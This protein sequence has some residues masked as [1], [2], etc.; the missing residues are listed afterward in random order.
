MGEQQQY[1]DFELKIDDL[2]GGRYRAT[3]IDMPLGEGEAQVSHEFTLPFEDEELTRILAILGGRLNISIA[4]RMRQAR[5]FGETLFNVVFGGPIYTVYFSSRDRA[6]TVSGLRVKLALE[7]AGALASLPWEFLRD[8]AVDYLALSR[9]T[10]LVRHPRRLVIRPRPKFALPLRVLVMVSSPV[11]MPPVDVQAEWNNLQVATET[12]RANGLLELELLADAS[13]RTLQ[14]KLRAEEYH[15]FHYIGHSTY[16]AE[17]GQGM[18][19]L[20]D[21]LGGGGS[22]PVR[23]ED[24]AREL[25]EE[26]TI[27]LVVLNSCQS[28]V[29][30]DTDPFAGIAS[31]IVARGIPAVVAM[32]H[33]IREQAARVFSEELYRSVADGLPVE[34]AMSEARR[35]ISHA[36]GGIQ[37]AVPVLYMRA[38]D[39]MLFDFGQDQR[40]AALWRD[41]R[42]QIGL[43]GAISIVALLLG[44]LLFGPDNE[45]PPPPTPA[46]D[47]AIDQIEV[48][49]TRPAPGQ[50]V[51]I[52]V[53]VTN[54]SN[55][56]VGP[57][58]Y[59]FREDVLDNSLSFVGEINGL[60]A[61]DTAAI[62]IPH[63]FSWW[64]AFVSEVRI[65]VKNQ[66]PE[67]DEFNN[68][69]RYPVVTNGDPFEITFKALPGGTAIQ[70][71]MPVSSTTFAA[72]GFRLEAIAGEAG[73]EA[74]IPWI[75]VDGDAR[76]L[77]TGLPEESGRCTGAGLALVLERD[78]VGGVSLTLDPGQAAEYTLVAF[79]PAHSEIERVTATVGAGQ[80]EL[81]IVS[82][83]FAVPLA[84]ARAE[85]QGGGGVSTRVTRLVLFE[86]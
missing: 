29:A 16:D 5:V 22:Y 71:S 51:A 4:E 56:A 42:V 17:T 84:V 73:C 48:F 33:V 68:L 45:P 14:R 43:A 26:N 15:V 6:R 77:G 18:L 57:F 3:V 74:V 9:T 67:T 64:N 41:R 69:A 46:V 82:G 61:G 50:K 65:D 12:L 35:A 39:G 7:D 38:A 52:I 55:T 78:S 54:R 24:L 53:H 44:L 70:H 21:P 80:D 37:W 20:E 2:G 25:S 31:S 8:P 11:D 34:A 30:H 85:L 27:R 49:P 47:L 19:A 10:P 81:S 58:S 62:Y 75:V 13:L 72:W 76:Y 66:V 83:E 63:A 1:L 79:D 28:A 23:G 60:S 59:D 40:A 86:P 36:V 32:Q